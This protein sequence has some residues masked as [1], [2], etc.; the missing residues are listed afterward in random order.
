MSTD[1][2]SGPQQPPSPGDADMEAISAMTS[3]LVSKGQMAP[4]HQQKIVQ[5]A[6]AATAKI[7]DLRSFL[8]QHFEKGRTLLGGQPA[9]QPARERVIDSISGTV[10]HLSRIQS[11][12]SLLTDAG[13]EV[14]QKVISIILGR[15]MAVLEDFKKHVQY[16]NWAISFTAGVPPQL[17]VGV[18][19][20]FQ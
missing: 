14:V 3:D 11:T 17:E 7:D 13:Q 8:D 16:Q 20:T 15:L 10:L 19:I 6:T 9:Q 5:S 4:E 2:A 1:P 18:Q 12:F